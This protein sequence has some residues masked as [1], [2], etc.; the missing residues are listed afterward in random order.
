MCI[1]LTNVVDPVAWL[2]QVKL[3]TDERPATRVLL[4]VPRSANRY[5]IFAVQFDAPKP[6]KRLN[7][8]S[9]PPPTT[10]PTLVAAKCAAAPCA[11]PHWLNVPAP[12]EP[13]AAVR[14]TKPGEEVSK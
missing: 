14:P 2:A 1:E 12:S 9:T 7:E 10:Q 5:S 8:V 6:N 4:T 3:Q 13:D 11:K